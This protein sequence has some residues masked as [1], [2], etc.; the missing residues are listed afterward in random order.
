MKRLRVRRRPSRLWRG[1]HRLGLARARL[2]FWRV[3]VE[4]KLDHR[5][6][7]AKWGRAVT[8]VF[9]WARSIEEA[10]GLASLALQSEGVEPVTADAMRW[11]PSARPSTA[12]CVVARTP[13]G[14]LPPLEEDLRGRAQRHFRI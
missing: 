2:P 13:F 9:V 6:K 7:V 3:V 4:G 5:A 14:Y 11:P 1:L 10:E 12:P 8:G